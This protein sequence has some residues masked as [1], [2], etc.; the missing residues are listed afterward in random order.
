VLE[1]D[2]SEEDGATSLALLKEQAMDGRDSPHVEPSRRTAGYQHG[3]M[4]RKLS[5]QQQALLV[6]V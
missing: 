3:G 1:K 2:P 6:T 5:R 4:A